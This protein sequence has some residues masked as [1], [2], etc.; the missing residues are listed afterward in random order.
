VG[1]ND[2]TLL[3]QYQA[4]GL[5]KVFGID[6]A[7]DIVKA[8]NAVG[9][10]T[11]EGFFTPDLAQSLRTERGGAALICANNVFAHSEH[12]GGF[13]Q[14]VR[15]LLAPEGVFVFEVSYLVDVVEK[16]LFDTIYH[17]HLAYHAVR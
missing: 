4:Q 16:L 13:A 11:L 17:E 3:K 9:V 5:T 14:G 1:S 12:L 7:A 2:G 10:P 15:T 8:A 6:P